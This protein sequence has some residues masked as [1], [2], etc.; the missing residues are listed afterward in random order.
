LSRSHAYEL[1]LDPERTEEE[2]WSS[3]FVRP[4]PVL[5]GERVRLRAARKTGD[6]ISPHPVY[7]GP[8]REW[9]VVAIQPTARDGK[10]VGLR[11]WGLRPGWGRSENGEPEPDPIMR[12]RLILRPVE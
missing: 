7:Y 6:P 5:L 9:E 10:A 11:G 12:G 2:R 8:E 3:T 1:P 4:Q